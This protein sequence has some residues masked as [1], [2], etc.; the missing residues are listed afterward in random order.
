MPATSPRYIEL[1]ETPSTNTALRS[2][3]ADDSR[4]AGGTV[5]Y[6]HRQTAGR[7]QRGNSWE[8]EPGMN[9]TFSMLLRP[10][11]I[12]AR[13]QFVVSEMVALGVAD[14][15]DSYLPAGKAAKVKWPNDIYVDDLKICGILI[16]NSLSGNT[17]DYSIAGIGLNVNQ[18]RFVSDAPNPVSIANLTGTDNDVVEVM[19]RVADAILD[20]SALSA[21]DIHRRYLD[22]LWRRQGWHPY[23]LPDGEVFEA[24]IADVATDGTLWLTHRDA[25]SHGY[26]FKEVSAI[27]GETATGR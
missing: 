22:R 16:E 15:L 13:R 21:D 12:E 11:G 3:L 27:V 24:V 14:A 9:A 7:G 1:A 10:E 17:I 25:T 20:L 19:G 23:R 5:V 4:I 6:T 18:R 2:M 26:L 8:A